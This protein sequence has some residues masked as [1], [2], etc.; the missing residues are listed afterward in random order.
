MSSPTDSSSSSSSKSNSSETQ[1]ISRSSSRLGQS[2]KT[3]LQRKSH[4]CS[5]SSRTFKSSSKKRWKDR[6]RSS[7]S[8][9]RSRS[10]RSR[11]LAQG[12]EDNCPENQGI[13]ACSIVHDQIHRIDPQDGAFLKRSDIK[14]GGGGG[15]HLILKGGNTN[16]FKSNLTLRPTLLILHPPTLEEI[17]Y[18]LSI[19]LYSEKSILSLYLTHTLSKPNKSILKVRNFWSLKK[20][21]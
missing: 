13:P 12:K 8:F 16:Y 9:C 19:L 1:Q 10:P 18:T 20:Y 3:R 17:Q 14:W 11:S 5:R 2:P 4:S 15:N 6:S 21:S 7:R